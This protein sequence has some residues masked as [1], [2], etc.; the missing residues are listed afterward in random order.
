MA[1]RWQCRYTTDDFINEMAR[2]MYFR[3][4]KQAIKK[5]HFVIQAFY[6]NQ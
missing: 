1:G 5:V 3:D 4:W 6:G 2:E